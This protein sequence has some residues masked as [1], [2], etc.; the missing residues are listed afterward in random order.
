M[1]ALADP[2]RG[3][4][5]IVIGEYERA[6]YGGRCASM[7]PLFA[8]Y[9]VKLWMPETGGPVGNGEDHDQLMLALGL[10]SKREFTRTRIASAPRWRPRP[11]SKAGTY[12]TSP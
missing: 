4:D 12:V 3:W 5:A 9:G 10:K 6:F 7:A 11:E 8:H 2:D 1:A